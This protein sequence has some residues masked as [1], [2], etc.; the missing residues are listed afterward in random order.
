MNVKQSAQSTNAPSP[1]M[2]D[3][4]EQPVALERFLS[5]MEGAQL[6]APLK[7]LL[8]AKRVVLAGM[9]SS[10]F[11]TYPIF[12]A[13]LAAGVPAWWIDSAELLENLMAFDSP[14]TVFWLTSQSGES[15]ET[16]KL[17]DLIR[18]D[19]FV[20]GIT[21]NS[22]STLAKRSNFLIEL[23]SG[24]EATVSAKSYVNSIAVARVVAEALGQKTGSLAAL[25]R[26]AQDSKL[27]KR[28]LDDGDVNIQRFGD[29]ARDRHLLITGRGEAAI[30]AE[31]AALILKEASKRPVEGMSAGVLR[32]GVIELAS[33]E[34]SVLIFDHSE[35]QNVNPDHA[36]ANQALAKELIQHGC[37]V[38]W[39]GG[40]AANQNAPDGSKVFEIN[41]IL[42]PMI[43]DA[44]VFQSL[45]FAF[46][47][48]KGIEAGS[49]KVASK[50]TT[51]I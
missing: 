18:Q 25:N 21:D 20:V 35:S 8:G 26:L 11:T 41:R 51:K 44:L 12:R 36:S 49:F 9:G 27:I 28:Y 13:M 16:T 33:P 3:V 6:E 50:V 46:A 34:T 40:I 42:D 17:V 47:E 29:F 48:R 5:S 31:A 22:E 1:F 45:S 30:S 38:G 43:G 23:K 4:L 15:G 2:A 32:H 14:D 10:H 37:E 19:S 24:P 39:V 7:K